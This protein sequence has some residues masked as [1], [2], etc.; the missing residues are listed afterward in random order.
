MQR[1]NR[2]RVRTA[3]LSAPEALTIRPTE[4]WPGLCVCGVSST[5]VLHLVLDVFVM[6]DAVLVEIHTH[7][8]LVLFAKDSEE[9]SGLDTGVVK[10][11]KEG[12][13]KAV[14]GSN[15]GKFKQREHP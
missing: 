15:T 2:C 14:A 9:L 3:R 12:A 13:V 1:V 7:A 4:T 10:T 6:Q 11:P 5:V 8:P